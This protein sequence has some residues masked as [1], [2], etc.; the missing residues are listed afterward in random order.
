MVFDIL[1]PWLQEFEKEAGYVVEDIREGM[2]DIIVDILEE[3]VNIVG[4]L[5]ESDVVRI[6]EVIIQYLHS[7]GVVKKVE[8]ELPQLEQVDVTGWDSATKN[9]ILERRTGVIEG[10][11]SMLKSGY[12]L[13]EPL[14]KEG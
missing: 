9:R 12:T 7:Q 4:I 10:Q 8:G 1:P 13:T 6:S 3:D 11:E 2:V 14:I 5:S